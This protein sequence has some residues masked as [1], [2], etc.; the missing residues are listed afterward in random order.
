[1]RLNGRWVLSRD[2]MKLMR[3]GWDELLK[4]GW[5]FDMNDTPVHASALYLFSMAFCDWEAGYGGNVYMF[6]DWMYAKVK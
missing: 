3:T 1:M 6:I 2:G 4:M 5:S